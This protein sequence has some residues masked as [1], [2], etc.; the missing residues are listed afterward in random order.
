[1]SASGASMTNKMFNVLW[2]PPCRKKADSPAD[3]EV[4][5]GA[6]P[7]PC[8]NFRKRICFISWRSRAPR[9]PLAARD[10]SH[11][12]HVGQYPTRAPDQDD[13]RGL[14]H[15]RAT[16]A[17]MDRLHEQGRITD[18]A[19]WRSCTPHQS[20]SSRIRQPAL[21][22]IN[23]YALGSAMMEDIERICREPDGR[24]PRVVSRLRRPRRPV[25]RCCA[26]AGT[27]TATRASSCNSSART[28]PAS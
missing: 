7:A 25:C 16:T 10:P 28:D 12:P 13:E 21:S 22:G 14:R 3:E 17:I 15:L 1:M 18:G 11:R 9:L 26:T 6:A 4:G 20:S 8:C 24:G 19:C 27:I 23:P 5:G 2:Y